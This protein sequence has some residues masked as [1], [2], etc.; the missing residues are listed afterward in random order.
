M[1][2]WQE[3]ILMPSDIIISPLQ[4]CKLVFCCGTFHYQTILMKIFPMETFYV[5]CVATTLW[6]GLSGCPCGRLGRKEVDRGQENWENWEER[7]QKIKSKPKHEA[8]CVVQKPHQAD[9]KWRQLRGGRKPRVHCYSFIL[10]LQF[11]SRCLPVACNSKW[12]VIHS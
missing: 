11:S 10:K 3:I 5:L 12:L 6:N 1:M 8:C 4:P 9:V 7:K 2:S